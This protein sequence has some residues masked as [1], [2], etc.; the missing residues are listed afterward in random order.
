M[1]AGIGGELRVEA[2]GD[3]T[4]LLDC[5]HLILPA[6]DDVDLFANADK[7]RSADEDPFTRA[8]PGSRLPLDF[9]D[10]GV[11]L[12]TI[13]IAVDIH[14]DQ[15]KTGWSL[16]RILAHQDGS[17][18]GAQKGQGTC[19]NPLGNLLIKTVNLEQMMQSG[20]FATGDHQMGNPLQLCGLF[21]FD[22]F[23]TRSMQGS[24]VG[25]HRSLQG[26][27]S[28]LN[29][30]Q[31]LPAAILKTLRFRKLAGIDSRH[32]FSQVSGG[33]G[34]FGRI[35]KVGGGMNDGLGGTQGIFRFED[36]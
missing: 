31:G 35:F 29:S 26:E 9:P 25:F 23:R 20:A 7:L 24:E 16:L 32:R 4:S 12:A 17:C 11:D 14:I 8:G 28:G 33:V 19:T 36:S 27:N 3:A 1:E 34:E 10:E 22:G 15:F 6:G 5:D 2:A 21:D 18:A 13:G 30:G